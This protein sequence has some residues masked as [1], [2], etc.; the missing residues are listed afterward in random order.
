MVLQMVSF[1]NV[2]LLVCL[3]CALW[4]LSYLQNLLQ[5]TSLK[6]RNKVCLESNSR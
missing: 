4:L 2:N 6:L 5:V 3:Q 1:Y